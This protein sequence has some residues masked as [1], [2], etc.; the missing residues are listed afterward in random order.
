MFS[1]FYRKKEII[2]IDTRP[3]YNNNKDSFFTLNKRI[4]TEDYKVNEF[5]KSYLEDNKDFIVTDEFEEYIRNILFN[6]LCIIINYNKGIKFVIDNIDTMRYDLGYKLK[7]NMLPVFFQTTKN[8]DTKDKLKDIIFNKIH[9]DNI[10]TLNIILN[11][12]RMKM[13]YDL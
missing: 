4:E 2:N 11:P 13:R 3:I 8:L 10:K 9:V 5:D 12:N 1:C 7:G 6:K